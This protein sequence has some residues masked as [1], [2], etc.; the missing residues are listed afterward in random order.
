MGLV[1]PGGVHSHQDHAVALAK[2]LAGARIPTVVH[3]FT[4]G[5]DTPP[6]SAADDLD[7]LA[8]DLPREVP[9]ATVSGRYYAMDRDARWERVTKAYNVIMDAQGNSFPNAQACDRRCLRA[10]AVRRIHR[11][12]CDRQLSRR[13]ERRWRA[14]L[15]LPLRSCARNPRRHPR[16]AGRLRLCPAQRRADR[17]RRRH[18]AVQR[19]ARPVHAG[20][21]PAADVSQHP[22]RG[23]RRRRPHA[24]S[25]GGDR[26]V[27]A[28]HVFLERRPRGTLS[29]ARRA[30][31]CR[32]R[33]SRP[34]T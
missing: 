5:R 33:R 28:R 26:E 24:A 19:G 22:R 18:D 11:A 10:A 6:Q 7:A 25:H 21:F 8:R 30:S 1:S 13:Q 15:Q 12:R 27:S 34:T 23:R 32:R 9:I 29:R 17:R 2:I 31:W 14:L 4:D 20:D 3:A 16:S